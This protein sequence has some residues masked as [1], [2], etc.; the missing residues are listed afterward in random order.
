MNA[1]PIL[2]ILQVD[3]VR[4]EFVG[5]HG[6][7]P[8]MFRGLFLASA[9]GAIAFRDY[10]VR[11]GDLPD[12]V[13]EADAW[14][15][16]GSRESVYDDIGWIAPLEEFIRKADDAHWPLVGICFGHQLVAQA[17]GGRTEP[18]DIGWAVGVH[19]SEIVA[20]PPWLPRHARAF[21]ILSSHKDQVSELPARAELLATNN[22]CPNAA[23]TVG[24]HLLCIQGHPEFS[25]A[26]ARDLMTFR[27]DLLGHAVYEAGIAS[28]QGSLDSVGVGRWILSFVAHAHAVRE[29]A[30]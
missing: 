8:A 30:A 21:S 4:E 11:A 14:V 7:Y 24:D 10:D 25:A 15:I 13:D 26:Y 19:R 12:R 9:D 2:G 17:L 23:F 16:T 29:A 3:S 28:L 27:R 20:R 18:A 5:T 1:R 22:L 6:D